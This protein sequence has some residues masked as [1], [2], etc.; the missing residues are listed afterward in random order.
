METKEQLCKEYTVCMSEYT[1]AQ[2]K[3]S[4]VLKRWYEIQAGGTALEWDKLLTDSGG[5]LEDEG[6]AIVKL[7]EISKKLRELPQ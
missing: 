5:A 4:A 3:V 6:R 2:K 7:Q 1:Q